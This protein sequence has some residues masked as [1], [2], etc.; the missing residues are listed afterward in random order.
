[1]VLGKAAGGAEE[2][3]GEVRRVVVSVVAVVAVVFV[4]VVGGLGFKRFEGLL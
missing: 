1:M 3:E 2:A 4:V